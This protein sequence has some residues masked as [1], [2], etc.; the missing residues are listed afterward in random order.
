MS[1]GMSAGSTSSA[2]R[3]RLRVYLGVAPGVG[4]TYAMLAE[5]KRLAERGVDVVVGLVE[6]HERADTEAMLAALEQ[7]PLAQT[8]HRGS[9]FDELDVD[10]V[11]ARRP[12]VVLVDE[13]AYTCVPGSRHEKRWEDV[14]E[15]LTAG[16]DVITALNV[17]HIDSLND[18]VE[19]V[20]GI[21]QH[22]TVPDAVVAGA[23]E[24]EFLD[25]T[26]QQ[27]RA[28]I[29][30]TDVL[31]PSATPHALTGFYAAERLA[32]LRELAMGW[33]Q[34]RGHLGA[35]GPVALSRPPAAVASQRVVVALT[36]DPDGEHVLRR[37]A[38]IATTVGGEL[39]GVHV[40]EPTGLVGAEPAWLTG[41]RRL[42]GELGGHYTELAGIDVAAAVLDFARN[43]NA[44]QLVL[45]ATRRSRRQELLHGSVINKAIRTAGPVEVHVIPARRP[46]RQRPAIRLTIPS[47]RPVPLPGLRRLAAW[48]LA[49][50]APVAIT[51]GM[52]PFRAP[53]GLAGA[54]LCN[55]LAVLCVALLGGVLPALLA[56]AVAVLMSDYFF[57]QPLHTLRVSNAVDVVALITFGIVAL[58]VGGLVDVL[59]RQGVRAAR[60]DAEA[61]NLARL[62]AGAMASPR[63]LSE[64]VDSIRRTFDLDAVAVL[65]DTGTGWNVE[66]AVG[67]TQLQHPDQADYQ[68]QLGTGRVLAI[69]DA[70]RTARDTAPLQAFLTELRLARGRALLQA[71][72]DN[73]PQPA[74]NQCQARP[75]PTP[76]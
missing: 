65:C 59:T 36:G 73:T 43:E 25:I 71:L 72:L 61:R 45:G 30:D 53:L 32:A 57:T 37:A 26:P 54:L 52:T 21:A 42:L 55:L 50:I 47:L 75:R 9:I 14:Q 15:L 17:Q 46:P 41:Q 48:I 33:L 6:T 63:D 70:R 23:D 58:A 4:K 3:G 28:R 69:I 31:R 76:A 11:L 40:R 62:A 18:A 27:L 22:E 13:L 35:A 20:T 12:A 56:T 49:V 64:A 66:T 34:Q 19:A 24:I 16:I 1:G 10:K 39:I 51:V 60:A 8:S 74:T 7:I 68:V 2:S 29:A 67:A 38:Q 44:H 5:A